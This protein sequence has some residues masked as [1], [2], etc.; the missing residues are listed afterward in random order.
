MYNSGEA[1]STESISQTEMQ[2]DESIPTAIFYSIS[3]LAEYIVEIRHQSKRYFINDKQEPMRFQNLNEAKRV[4]L[5]H[6]AERGFLALNKTYQELDGTSTS[7]TNRFD[8]VGVDL[9]SRS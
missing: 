7:Q 8:Y 3:D 4:A 9:H 5:E 6:K 1:M 2:L